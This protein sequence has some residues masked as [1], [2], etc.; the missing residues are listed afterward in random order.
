[1]TRKQRRASGIVKI[2][3]DAT[4]LTDRSVWSLKKS[5]CVSA[6]VCF[7]IQKPCRW[8]GFSKHPLR[9][10]RVCEFS[11]MAFHNYTLSPLTMWPIYN[12]AKS[13]KNKYQIKSIPTK[14]PTNPIPFFAI[15]DRIRLPM[16]SLWDF[17]ASIGA[18]AI[19]VYQIGAI[20]EC[21]CSNSSRIG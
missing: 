21:Y 4:D 14:D 6:C 7:Q 2:L 5:F 11:T 1:M 8:T 18:L 17:F 15:C 10:G 19:S 12:D 3:G 9:W 20:S 13:I 16:C